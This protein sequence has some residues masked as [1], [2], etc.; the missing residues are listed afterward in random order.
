MA[1][2]NTIRNP[3]YISAGDMSTTSVVGPWLNIEGLDNIGFQAV[4]TGGTG[5]F[6]VEVSEDKGV[7][8]DD[9]GLLA[10]DGRLGPSALTL[11]ASMVVAAALPA[12]TAGNFYFDF[13]QITAT[14]IRFSYVK[15]S[16][17]GTL[18]VGAS[19]KGI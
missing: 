6:L 3:H 14:W 15:T 11:P 12:G 5:T 7:C 8:S 2:K 9:T 19:A 16:G 10:P 13:N 17:T 18:N 1:N 4:W